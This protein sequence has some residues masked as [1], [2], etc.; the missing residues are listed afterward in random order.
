MKST[1]LADHNQVDTAQPTNNG[2]VVLQRQCACGQRTAAGGECAKCRKKRLSLQRHAV[3]RAGPTAAPPIVH[4]VLRSPGQRLDSNVRSYMESRFGHD[5]SG[6][7]VHT[8]AKAGES[9]HMVNAQ[10]FTAGRDVVFGRGHYAPQ[11]ENGRILLAHELTHVLQQSS[12]RSQQSAQS[13]LK[14]STPSDPAEREAERI[15]KTINQ[16]SRILKPQNGT[17]TD[18]LS[19]IAPISVQSFPNAMIM[20]RWDQPGASD[21]TDIPQDR[22]LSKVVVEQETPQSVT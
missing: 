17:G 3:N 12:H 15:A 11:T 19:Q 8:D 18:G 5:F 16:D 4:E 10:A 2:Q 13:S 1:Y 6:V 7:R 22:W 21:C 14:I 9:A 20:R